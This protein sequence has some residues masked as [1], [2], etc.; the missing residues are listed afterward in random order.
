MLPAMANTLN[1]K[2]RPFSIRHRRLLNDRSLEDLPAQVRHRLWSTLCTVSETFDFHHDDNPGY[3]DSSSD[4][5]EAQALYG[6]LLGVPDDS[7]LDDLENR[8]ICG[9]TQDCF[10]VL[11]CF[12]AW[13][14]SAGNRMPIAQRAI[15]ETL[16]DFHLPWRMSEGLVFQVDH[17]YLEDEILAEVAPLLGLAEFHGAHDEFIKARD[18]LTDGNARDAISYANAS[19]ESALKTALGGCPKIGKE[20]VYEYAEKGLMTGLPMDKAKE[21][22]HSL[23]ALL[24][25]RNSLAAHGQGEKVLDVPRD[26]AVLAV[27]LAAVL[28]AFVTRQHL[29]REGVSVPKQLPKTAPAPAPTKLNEVPAWDDDIPF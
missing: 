24:T 14:D 17:D 6:R 21:V 13:L 16:T 20:L 8:V 27:G 10:D 4:L 3:R 22:Q 28:N 18:Y 25:L 26:Y 5:R 12:C 15:N 29:A 1:I 19:L 11:E 9:A 2:L 7:F 23:R